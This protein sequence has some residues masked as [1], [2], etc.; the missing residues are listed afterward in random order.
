MIP[1]LGQGAPDSERGPAFPAHNNERF[2]TAIAAF[3][4][5][6]FRSIE[7]AGSGLK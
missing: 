5:R 4:D 3:F 7:G 6:L 2:E 1:V